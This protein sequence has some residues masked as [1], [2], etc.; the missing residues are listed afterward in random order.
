MIFN[1]YDK[2]IQNPYVI[3]AYLLVGL[4]FKPS[5]TSFKNKSQKQITQAGKQNG[6]PPYRIPLRHR[7]NEARME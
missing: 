7:G 4:M 6:Y 1:G 3:K 2:T 5:G